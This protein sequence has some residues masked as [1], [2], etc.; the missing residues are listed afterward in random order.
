MNYGVA[1]VLSVMS[2]AAI[3]LITLAWRVYMSTIL[4]E[5]ENH[6]CIKFEGLTAEGE[7]PSNQFLIVHNR[8]GLLLDCGGYRVYKTIL[9]EMAHFLPA[10]SLD[11]IFLSHQ[12]PDIGSGINL[13]LPICNAK[14]LVSALWERFVPAF[15]VRG[16][17]EGRLFPIPDQGVR[18]QL[19]DAPLMAIAAHFLHSPGNFHLYDPVAKILFTSDLG[20]SVAAHKAVI[21]TDDDFRLHIENMRGFHNRYM[22]SNTACRNWAAMVRKLDVEM[23]V[24]QHG[25]HI[26]GKSL[27]ET[28]YQWVETEK[29]ALDD[30]GDELFQLPNEEVVTIL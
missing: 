3:H 29:T 17:A 22:P 20:A 1:R 9:G 6:K 13:W 26:V 5:D 25:A 24:P 30:F 27:V 16:I 4:Y 18:F 11:Y 10:G 19:S 12:D 8:R 14:I 15:C 28:F 21:D 23:I 7:I 2:A